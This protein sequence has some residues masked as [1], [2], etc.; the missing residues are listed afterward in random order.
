MHCSSGGVLAAGRAG[1]DEF[2]HLDGI[3]A[4]VWPG[5][6]PGWLGTWG[7]PEFSRR[8]DRQREVADEVRE[9]GMSATPTLAY[10][11]SQW[12]VRAEDFGRSEAMRHVP[13]EMIEW[14]TPVPP[15]PGACS[16]WGKALE[17]A[18]RFVGLLSERGVPLLAGSDVPCG[19]VPPGASLWRELLLLTGAG[20]SGEQA[21]RSATSG[22]AVLLGRPELG[23][24][25]K[26]SVADLIFVRGNPLERIPDRPEVVAVVRDGTAFTPEDLLGTARKALESWREDPWARQFEI[27]DSRRRAAP[28]T[29]PKAEEGRP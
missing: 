22:A 14:Q 26:G 7:L 6:P 19:P 5:H 29:P 17:A 23:R 27:H 28:S 2:H 3:L 1:V 18:Q 8:W 4:D 11:D 21:L 15:D 16:R 25:G 12:R 10:W 24:L 20:L 13:P 9:L